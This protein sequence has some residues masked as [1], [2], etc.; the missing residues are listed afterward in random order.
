MRHSASLCETYEGDEG[1]AP[2]AIEVIMKIMFLPRVVS[3][4]FAEAIISTGVFRGRRGS[5]L[6]RGVWN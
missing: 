5:E 1:T 4:L 3:D 6:W 2:V